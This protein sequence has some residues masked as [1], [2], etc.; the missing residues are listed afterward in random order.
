MSLP[1]SAQNSDDADSFYKAQLEISKR[2]NA[3][4]QDRLR[5]VEKENVLLKKAVF[6]LSVMPQLAPATEELPMNILQILRNMSAS[7]NCATAVGKGS[8]FRRVAPDERAASS[9]RDLS[10]A[11]RAN[12]P[13]NASGPFICKASLEGHT[14][15]V[16]AIQFSPNG[17]LL[18]STS[19]DRSVCIWAM[20]KHLDKSNYEPHLTFPDAHRSQ[21]VAVEWTS[22][23]RH[24]VT[25]GFDQYASEWDIPSELGK[26]TT[27]F[28]CSGL[29][30]A[31][32]V[33]PAND[34]LF[35]APTSHRVV[36]LFDRRAPPAS[37]RRQADPTI[38]V[39]NDEVVNTVNVQLDGQRFV[40]GDRGGAIKTWDLRMIPQTGGSST[41][42]SSSGSG[43]YSAALYHTAFN[44]ASRRPITHIHNSPP[45]PG[46]NH[47]RFMAVN[48]YDD[49]LRIYDRGSF[50]FQRKNVEFK[51][52]HALHGPQNNNVPIKSSFFMGADYSPARARVRGKGRRARAAPKA[53]RNTERQHNGDGTGKN[54][55]NV[56]GSS[57]E[58]LTSSDSSSEDD[59]ANPHDRHEHRR[60]V[61]WDAGSRI[62]ST[63]TLA[64]GSADGSVYL[65]DIGGRP[66]TAPLMQR[67][68]EH[69]DKV[70]SVDFH[71]SEPILASCSADTQIKIFATVPHTIPDPRYH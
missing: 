29:V 69:Q 62:Q 12:G 1:F 42:G 11:R 8:A 44:E 18:A 51:L 31:V 64:T 32:T 45:V 53:Q 67:L 52:V 54:D 3:Q 41:S 30:N 63:I 7:E 43:R 56:D 34:A 35:F 9:A 61:G 57:E 17:H 33:S 36:H 37:G 68:E 58:L 65:F 23:S 27:R 60:R 50:I 66:G 16:Y 22:D 10:D 19:F 48:S 39:E 49:Y 14:S 55:G 5:T 25:G 6:E 38:I 59:Q 40:T 47:G 21:V 46:D 24:I 4:L 28:P 2:E 71:P 70:Y 13:L 26:A 20:D 15:A